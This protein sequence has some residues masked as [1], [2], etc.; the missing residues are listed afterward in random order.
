MQS[1]NFDNI[2]SPIGFKATLAFANTKLYTFQLK[3][4]KSKTNT[5]APNGG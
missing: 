1:I 5:I 2:G 4:N 3:S